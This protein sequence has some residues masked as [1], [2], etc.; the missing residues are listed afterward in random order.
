MSSRSHPVDMDEQRN[1]RIHQI[2]ND[3][4]LRRS[5]GEVVTDESIIEAH[6]DLMPELAERLR[7]LH[8]IQEAERQ[9][10][11]PASGNI[12]ATGRKHAGHAC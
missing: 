2:V 11:Q 12:V 3:C 9:S 4:L 10:P 1:E 6:A 7:S 5:Q 8:M